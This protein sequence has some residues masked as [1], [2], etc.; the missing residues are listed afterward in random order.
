MVNDIN[1]EA[2]PKNELSPAD[3]GEKLD[4][5]I[6]VLERVRGCKLV[7]LFRRKKGIVT[8][9][10]GHPI[11][12]LPNEGKS[13]VYS[14]RDVAVEKTKLKKVPKHSEKPKAENCP[15]ERSSP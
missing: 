13:V 8:A 5:T 12:I 11:S 4:S 9:E 2:D 6:L 1:S 7:E 10:I 15:E 3:F 14:K